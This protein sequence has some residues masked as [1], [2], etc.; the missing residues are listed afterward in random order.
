MGLVPQ[1][2]SYTDTEGSLHTF[3]SPVT[4]PGSPRTRIHKRKIHCHRRHQDWESEDPD[5]GGVVVA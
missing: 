4:S 2:K 5:S 1:C 3:D